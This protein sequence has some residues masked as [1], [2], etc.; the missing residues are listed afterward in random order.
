MGLLIAVTAHHQKKMM[1]RPF[2]RMS[3]AVVVGDPQVE[4]KLRTNSSLHKERMLG[5]VLSD[6]RFTLR[7]DL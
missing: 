7:G 3:Q 4:H 6:L 1:N 5:I 2:R